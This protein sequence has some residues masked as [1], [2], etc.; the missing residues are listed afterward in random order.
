MTSSAKT[1]KRIIANHLVIRS[2]YP[3]IETVV[4]VDLISMMSFTPADEVVII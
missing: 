2:V 1:T 4:N 3:F